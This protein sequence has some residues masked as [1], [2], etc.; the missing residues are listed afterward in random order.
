[1]IR[2]IEVALFDGDQETIVGPCS[3]KKANSRA[4]DFTA[5]Q[6]TN[7]NVS[8]DAGPNIPTHHDAPPT[9]RRGCPDD[10]CV[11]YEGILVASTEATYV[12]SPRARLDIAIAK[13]VKGREIEKL[14][15]ISLLPNVVMPSCM[16]FVLPC[17]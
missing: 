6:L 5:P 17:I 13:V 8:V 2:H 15:T 3:N 9:W 11:V 16:N 12:Y 14:V 4:S 7:L 10:S 1:V